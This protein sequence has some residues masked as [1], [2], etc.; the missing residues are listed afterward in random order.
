MKRLNTSKDIELFAFRK[1]A[2][3]DWS[4]FLLKIKITERTDNPE[5]INPVLDKLVDDGW[6]CDLRFAQCYIR[7]TRNS[8]G[9]GPVKVRH[10]LKEKGISSNII[11]QCLFEDHSIWARNAFNI[12]LKK[13]GL[14][15]NNL[16]EKYKQSNFLQSRGF[17]FHQIEISFMHQLP[18]EYEN[19]TP[20]EEESELLSL[21][22][23]KAN[24]Y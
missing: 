6:L 20:P 7:I 16:K 23:V 10:N 2:G 4:Y 24:I 9:Y 13:Y 19:I 12:R 14:T 15:P 5:L 1:L 22:E 3:Q 17:T 8:K 18:S 21:D 11:E